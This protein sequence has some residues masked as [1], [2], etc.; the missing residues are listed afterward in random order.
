MNPN[1][2]CAR[3][4]GI[5]S[6]QGERVS[7]EESESDGRRD[8]FRRNRRLLP[9]WKS[10]Q[11]K[12]RRTDGR[13]KVELGGRGRSCNFETNAPGRRVNKNFSCRSRRKM[14]C[15]F[16]LVSNIFPFLL[17]RDLKHWT[18]K[19]RMNVNIF[20]HSNQ[21][22]CHCQTDLSGARLLRRLIMSMPFFARR[23]EQFIL[24]D[25]Q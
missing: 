10:S 13:T 2:A 17:Q 7:G 1:N 5:Q 14:N 23:G 25:V 11:G 4:S 21:S 3:A 6:V 19:L 15:Y 16:R 12:E 24:G 20:E 8:G 18:K 9:H 22:N